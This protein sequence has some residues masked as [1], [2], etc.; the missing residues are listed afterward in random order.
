MYVCVYIYIYIYNKK[1]YI[2]N[3]ENTFVFVCRTSIATVTG[4]NWE[5]LLLSPR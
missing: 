1:M 3:L 5:A 4:W 2:Y